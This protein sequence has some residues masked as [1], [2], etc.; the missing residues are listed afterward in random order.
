MLFNWER[1]VYIK[2]LDFICF[3]QF[4]VLAFVCAVSFML[5]EGGNC[6]TV[7]FMILI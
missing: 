1:F 6:F 5:H 3:N 7:L 4:G 2:I